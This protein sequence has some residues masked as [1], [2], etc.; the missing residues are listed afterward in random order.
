MEI[1]TDPY[2]GINLK[3][4]LKDYWKK[5]VGK[6]RIIYKIDE[7]EKMVLFND[8]DETV[9]AE[10]TVCAIQYLSCALSS[11]LTSRPLLQL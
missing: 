2:S 4:D 11:M 10:E 5:K 8:L 1:L 7:S 6:Y 9:A 3:A